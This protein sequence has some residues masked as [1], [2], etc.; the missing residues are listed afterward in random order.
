MSQR[1]HLSQ[2][3]GTASLKFSAFKLESLL[4]FVAFPSCLE[5]GRRYLTERLKMVAVSLRET[6]ICK[7]WSKFLK[8]GSSHGLPLL[9][10]TGTYTGGLVEKPRYLNVLTFE[11]KSNSLT[12][13]QLLG[14]E[15]WLSG[16][17]IT[18]FEEDP[19]EVPNMHRKAHNHLY[20][21][22]LIPASIASA[23]T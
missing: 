1:A 4:D 23:H 14:L 16:R 15:R 12:D 22:C 21:Q 18:T 6:I 17:V 8:F 10:S 19:S 7:L 2:N 20:L 9:S 13:T 5:L 11:S 3:S